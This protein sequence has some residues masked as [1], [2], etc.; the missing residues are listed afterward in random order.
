MARAVVPQIANKSLCGHRTPEGGLPPR[1]RPEGAGFLNRLNHVVL[2]EHLLPD[3]VV[4]L[5][6]KKANPQTVQGSSDGGRLI[7]FVMREDQQ[8]RPLRQDLPWQPSWAID[9]SLL[10]RGIEIGST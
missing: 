4:R 7:P 3:S 9:R 8:L 5:R 6:N 2:A 10:A 1:E